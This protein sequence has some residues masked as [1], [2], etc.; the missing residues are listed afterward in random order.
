MLVGP[1]RR[2]AP[3][4]ALAAAA[5]TRRVPRCCARSPL[6]ALVAAARRHRDRGRRQRRPGPR[7]LDATPSGSSPCRATAT[8]TGASPPARSPTTRSRDRHRRASASS[9]CA[10]AR[11]REARPRR[12]LALPRDRGRAGARRPRSRCRAPRRRGR[13]ARRCARDRRAR[14]AALA[15]F[16]LHAG[17]DWDWELPAL[18]LVAVLLAARCR[19][20]GAVSS[21]HAP[22]PPDAVTPPPGNPRFPLLDPLRA[23]AALF[24]V[25]THTAQLGGFNREHFA[26]RA[27]RS[28]STA[29]WRSSS[30]CR[31]FL[32]YRPF[33]AARLD[34][35]DAPRGP[36]LR[37]AP[38]A[39]HPARLLGRADRAR[40]PRRHG[41]RRRSSATTG[42]STSAC[43]RAGAR[44]R[45]SPASAW[46]GACSVEMA[47]YVLLPIYALLMAKL[48]APPRPRR[49]GAAGA[50]AAGRERGRRGRGAG[51]GARD[52]ARRR[53]SATSSG[54][55][56]RGSSA[57]SCWPSPARGWP[58]ATDA[59]AAGPIRRRAPAGLL[60]RSRSR[61]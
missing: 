7:E 57:A 45:S 8:R 4:C 38:R 40:A 48:L 50:E 54:A 44:R 5:A 60:G 21:P 27:G 31:R 29:A 16:A 56:G 55:P 32:L 39:A 37:P 42:G 35:R 49:P 41:T 11:S 61:A 25:V 18:T 24:V 28:A 1:G 15:A 43:S 23:I 52:L 30:C 2:W 10:S 14:V 6:G 19:R 13:R 20:P 26:R 46:P 36:A 58:G 59:P 17:L 33:V 34:E 51:R 9:G 47:F 22:R 12:A 3:R 53:C